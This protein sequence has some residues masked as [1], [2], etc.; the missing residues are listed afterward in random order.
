MEQFLREWRTEALNKNQH[1][2]AIFIGDKLL[3][4]TSTCHLIC[5]IPE[6]TRLMIRQ[7]NRCMVARPSP[8]PEGQLPSRLELHRPPRS[9]GLEPAMPLFVR[10][11]LYQVGEVERRTWS[12]R[13]LQ[14]NTSNQAAWERE[15]ETTTC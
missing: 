1:D 9:V 11:V 5:A 15:K 13:G 10:I 8:L 4:L 2:S 6:L 12:A 14:S 3:A 7:Y